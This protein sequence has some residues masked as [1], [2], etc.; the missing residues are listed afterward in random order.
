MIKNKSSFWYRE[1]YIL[2][3]SLRKEEDIIKSV[4]RFMTYQ[5][6]GNKSNNIFLNDCLSYFFDM[7]VFNGYIYWRNVIPL[8]PPP[9][10]SI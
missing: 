7:A 10:P 5:Q 8:H 2:M 4:T 9:H 1:L 6:P 3:N